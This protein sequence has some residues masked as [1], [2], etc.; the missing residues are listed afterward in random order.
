MCVVL[1]QRVGLTHYVFRT[2]GD[3]S[4]PVWRAGFETHTQIRTHTH[5]QTDRNHSSKEAFL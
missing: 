1:E 2:E 5:L 3:L 4:T